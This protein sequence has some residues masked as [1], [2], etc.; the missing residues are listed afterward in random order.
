[1][2]LYVR[3][4]IY[5]I[6]WRFLTCCC[7]IFKG[8]H[9]FLNIVQYST[10]IRLQFKS[11]MA[12]EIFWACG[13]NEQRQV[14]PYSYEWICSWNEK[15]RETEETMDWYYTRRL[16]WDESW[17]TYHCS[18][19]AWLKTMEGVCEW[20]SCWRVSTRHRHG[21]KSSKSYRIC[22]SKGRCIF[23]ACHSHHR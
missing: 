17:S 10:S 16:W 13:K 12:F 20:M 2:W 1:M 15:P 14:S 4:K 3:A 8:S 6:W 22:Q 5:S 23:I 7:K 18:H 9:F 19:G 11:T 21:N